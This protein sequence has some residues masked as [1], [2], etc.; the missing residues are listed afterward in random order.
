MY[1]KRV[2][3]LTMACL[4]SSAALAT[5]RTP[6]DTAAKPDMGKGAVQ[7]PR[8]DERS[9]EEKAADIARVEAYLSTIRSIVSDFSQ[10]SSDGSTG[11]GKFF[12][13]RPGKMRWQYNPPT[14]ILLVSDGKT[15][16]YYDAGLD[17][18]SY[19]G[20]DDTLGGFLT[21]KELKLD[22]ESTKL[23]GFEVQGTVVRATIVQRKKPSEGSL[24]LEFSYKPLELKKIIAVDATGNETI[25]TLQ[26]P[27]FGPVLDDKLFIF[28]DPRGVN[29]KRNKR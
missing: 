12:L 14:P 24:T 8:G 28:E 16:T 27:Q 2:M 1:T 15:V 19:V 9:M 25:V 17:Q 22:S 29:H 11:T 5:P 13:K 20:M 10:T 18:I 23:T 4:L 21:K 3:I 6:L 26:K 7:K